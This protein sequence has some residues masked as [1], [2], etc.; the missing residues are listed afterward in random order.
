M[1]AI[2]IANI[3]PKELPSYLGKFVKDNVPKYFKSYKF[4]VNL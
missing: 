3:R 4:S 1:N 2:M